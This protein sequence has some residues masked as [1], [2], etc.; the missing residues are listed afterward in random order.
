MSEA[1]C[2]GPRLSA[3]LGGVARSIALLLAT[4]NLVGACTYD[5]AGITLGVGSADAAPGV[6]RVDAAAVDAAAVDVVAVDA[7]VVDAPAPDTAA[8]VAP[9]CGNG[10]IESGETCDPSSACRIQSDACVNDADTIRARMGDVAGCSFR[11]LATPRLCG[12]TP[13]TF[14]PMM[15]QPCAATCAAGQDIDC[16]L[17]E[18][19]ACTANNQCRTACADGACCNTICQGPCQ[20]CDLA[21]SRGTCT[22]TSGMPRPGH[23]PCDRTDCPGTCAA[24]ADG[25]CTYPAC[26]TCCKQNVEGMK[27]FQQY[28]YGCACSDCYALCSAT[29]CDTNDTNPTPEC[30]A[31]VKAQTSDICQRARQSCQTNTACGTFATCSFGCS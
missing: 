23:T 5:P 29:L 1:G 22:A 4:G 28:L 20:A 26:L 30:L 18:G 12:A 7:A 25:Q 24:R 31:C 13:D 15:C 27:A 9:S 6:A 2:P 17:P 8:D 21:G 11:C 3:K 16:K 10:T 19:A 14:C